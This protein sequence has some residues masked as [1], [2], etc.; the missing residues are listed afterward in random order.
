MSQPLQIEK[1]STEERLR[2][3]EQ[4]W[5]SLRAT[6]EAIPLTDAQRAELDR[7]LDELDGGDVEGIPWNEVLRRIKN[8][9]S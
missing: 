2:L 4:L 8:R 3:I 7:R 9:S 1:L 5:E 6:P